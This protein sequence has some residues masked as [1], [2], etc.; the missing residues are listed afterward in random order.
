[1]LN[2][3]RRRV[4]ATAFALAL[5]G[6]NLPAA[7]RLA[8]GFASPPADA[9]PLVWWHWVN[10]NI[11][12]RG[13]E[14]D[15][16]DMKRVGI[17][18]AQMFDVSI[19]SPP[20]P[21]RYGTD[22][23]HDHVQH[24][25][26]TAEKTGLELHLMNTPG[27][28]ASGG[29]WVTPERSMKHLVWSETPVTGGQ[30]VTVALPSP[31]AKLGFYRDVAVLAVPADPLSGA[32]GS[33]TAPHRLAD[34]TVKTKMAE[35]TLRRP[36]FDAPT[37]ATAISRSQIV[38]LTARTDATGR[39]RAELPPGDWTILRF[40]FT[41]TGRKNHPAVAEGEGLEID[42][43]DPDAVSFYFDRALGRILREAGPRAGSTFRA[44]LFDSFEGGPQNWTD[45]FPR[46]FTALKGYDLIPL[47][48]AI[49]GRL[50]ETTSFTESVLHDFRTAVE[51]TIARQYF[52]TMRRRAHEHGLITYAEAQGGP[53]N[54][55]SS[56]EHVDVPMN[57]FWMP[58][59]TPR[60]P[61]IKLIS[62]VS[63]LLG[64]RI[65][66]AES[67]TSTPE[68]GRW[69]NMP[70]RLKIAGDAAWTAGINRFILHHYTHQPTD[71][72][73]GFGLGRY[74]TNFGRLNSWWPLAGAWIDYL[75]RSQ[76]LLQQGRTVADL[77]FLQNEDH[78]YS[79]PAAMI[80]A[81]AGY[82]FDICY[83]RHLA[84]MT[85]RDGALT[86]PA[87]PAYRV[88]LLP[89][90][91]AADIAT[92]QRLREFARAGAPIFGPPPVAPA[93]VRDYERH[94]EFAALVAELWGADSRG[95][96]IRDRKVAAALRE[97][98]VPPDVAWSAA[99]AGG[100]F[101]FIHRRADDAD[102]YFVFNHSNAPF[103]ADVTFRAHR[104]VPELWNAIDGT[105]HDA[106][107][108][109]THAAGTTVPLRLE[110]NG[111]RFVVFRR[112]LP[113][114]WVESIATTAES[115]T[116]HYSDGTQQSQR[117]R[118]LPAPLPVAGPW[119]V[120]FPDGRGAPAE[121]ELAELRSWTEHADPGVKYYSGTAEYRA[122]VTISADALGSGARA[123]LDLGAVADLAEVRFNG[124]IVRV[125]WQ[126]PFRV[127]ITR[128]L[129]SGENTVTVRVA[130]RWINRIIGDEHIPTELSYQPVG[131]NKF[132]DGRLEKL[133]GWL[134][135]RS[136]ISERKRYSFTTWRH[137]TADSPLVPAGLLGPVKIE[138]SERGDF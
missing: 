68:N 37:P 1:M 17:A 58:E 23:W 126:P 77:C 15:L 105:R 117:R 110:P 22:A 109:R 107:A 25:I 80:T 70:S 125:L 73:P 16:A 104:R 124:E 11:S 14:A 136:R 138:W 48:P 55:V 116:R 130:N 47:L 94:A 21:V 72:G 50:I 90:N 127:D 44:I 3:R 33:A 12:K 29:P 120:A 40:G 66:A 69:Q 112:A 103:S 35:A 81:P 43:M 8:D 19:Y 83:P 129:R 31:A 88:L 71:D 87:G 34:W 92:L 45:T 115:I 4:L 91:W 32:S 56:N 6:S 64:R 41:S 27:W 36:P 89:E 24:A 99:P 78:G 13:I 76:F 67:F 60:I 46:Q 135:D 132:T 84:A 119:R 10:G 28:S 49:T 54:P 121:T 118:A 128:F 114:R 102:I 39:L 123:T 134:Y 62:S 111:S 59:T 52:G 106:P 7:D 65:V 98:A 96:K 113:T 51:E 63:N 86:L 18:G 101:R 133:P 93:G 2:P 95:A 53:L 122:T 26:R 38:D 5:P 137:Y 61:R 42:K 131:K 75:A 108:F 97:A 100:E 9:R 30:A 85:W 20:G 57:E 74:G 79:F 82:A